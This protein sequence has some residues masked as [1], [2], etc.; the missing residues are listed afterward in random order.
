[1]Q[2]SHLSLLS[3]LS[4]SSHQHYRL[5]HNPLIYL[6]PSTRDQSEEKIRE[7][8][9]NF[10]TERKEN[11]KKEYEKIARLGWFFIT[12]AGRYLPLPNKHK[13]AYNSNALFM[14]FF[15]IIYPYTYRTYHSPNTH[16]TSVWRLYGCLRAQRKM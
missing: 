1:M 9:N 12:V 5:S 13:H 6:Y 4:R 16:I 7:N 3:D 10:F 15:H 8:Y 11:K 14:T 2:V